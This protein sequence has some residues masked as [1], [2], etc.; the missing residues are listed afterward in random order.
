[1]ILTLFD[2]EQMYTLVLPGQVTGRYILSTVTEDGKPFDLMAVEAEEGHWYLKSNKHAFIAG[3]QGEILIKEKIEPFRT[4]VI[5]RSNGSRAL[6]YVEP[7]T[8]DRNT[9]TKHLV[10]AD[11]IRIGRARDSQ[12]CIANKL[13]S[14]AHCVIEY[15]ANGQ[16]TIIDTNSSN[17]TFVNGKKITRK[18]LEIGDVIYIMGVKIIYNGRLLSLNNP[19]QSVLLDRNAFTPFQPAKPLVEKEEELEDFHKEKEDKDLFFRSPRFKRDIKRREI[20]IDPVPSKTKKDETPLMLLLGPSLTMGLASVMMAVF[21]I[22]NVTSRGGTWTQ[23][24]PMIIM[25]V[26]IL[27]GTVMWPILTKR[28]EKKK[29]AKQEQI[30]HEKYR[31]YLADMRKVIEEE[32]LHQEE[33]LHENHPGLHDYI[34]RIKNRERNLWERAIG[35]DD[36]LLIRVGI[37]DVPL[38]AD[39]K[40]PEKRFTLEDDDLQDELYRLAE[41]PQILRQ[42]PVTFSLIEEKISGIIGERELVIPFVKGL[43][44][45]LTALHSYD[46]CKL[47][48]IYDKS[49]DQIW[50]FVR[51]LPHV[52]DES[53]TIRFIATEANEMKELSSYFEKEI[54][55]RR[56]LAGH[57]DAEFP[58]HYVIF[59]MNK[60]LAAKGEMIN[61]LL[62]EKR[63][64]GFSLITLYDEL[65]D[66]P[67][68]CSTVVELGKEWSKIYDKDDI[69]GRY[70][71][72]KADFFERKDEEEIAI[73]LANTKLASSSEAYRLPDMITFLEMFGVGKIEHLNALERWRENDPTKSLETPI[74]VSTTG[75]LFYLDLHE[76]YHGPHGLVAGMTGSGKSE[77]IM[78]FIL[79]LAVNYHP[80]EVAFILIDYKGGGMANAFLD[81]PHLAGTITNLDGASVKRS[82]VSIQSELKRRQAI[83]SETSRKINVS[84]IDIYKYQKLY[85]EG[86]V[87]EPLQ[88]LFIISDE[89]AELKTQQPEFMEQL[90]SAARIGR[91]LGVHLILATQKPSGV[92]DDQIWSNSKF[93]ICLKVQE[94]QDSMEVIKRPDAAELAQTGR[95][96]L[97]VG[98]NELFEL[99]QSAWSG[100]PYIPADKAEK[101]EDDSV[102]VI[103][104]LGRVIKRAKL[105]KQPRVKNPPKQIDEIVKYLADLAAGENIKVRQLWL[106]PI[107]ALIYLDEL[108]KKY[109]MPPGVWA[110]GFGAVGGLGTGGLLASGFGAGTEPGPSSSGIGSTRSGIGSGRWKTGTLYPAYTGV[111]RELN[112]V[113]GEFDDPANQRQ[114]VLTMPITKEGNAVIYGVTGSGKTTFMST[115]VFSL[116]DTYTPEEVNLYLLDFGTETLRW[117]REAP[118]VGD[119][120]LSHESEK[121]NNLFMLLNREMAARKKKLAEFGGDMAVYN[122]TARDKMPAIVVVIHNYSV[123]SEMY[124]RHEE[125][126]TV[127]TR[128]GTKY[129]LYFVLTG[130][131]PDAVRYRLLQNFKQLFVLQLNDPTDYAGILGN[132]DGVYPSKHKGRGIFKTDKVYEFQV[133]HITRN[134]DDLYAFITEYCRSLDQ[135]WEGRRAQRVPVLPEKVDIHYLSRELA[136]RKGSIWPVGV[137]KTTL[138]TATFDFGRP[139]HLVAASD[140]ADTAAFMQGLAEIFTTEKGAEVIVFDPDRHFRIPE[141]P[142]YG[143]V[144]GR[145]E[146]EPKIVELFMMLVH[147]HNTTKDAIEAGEEPPEFHHVIML[148]HSCSE[149]LALLSAD[150]KDKLKVFLDKVEG[151][152]VTVIL[153]DSIQKMSGY[154]FDPWF[155][156]RVSVTDFVWVG[157]GLADQ[158]VLKPKI[159]GDMYKEIPEGFGYLVAKGKARLVKLLSASITGEKEEEGLHVQGL[160]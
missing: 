71:A 19:H 52:W 110:S 79:S 93:R 129:G 136:A 87:K 92:V 73:K 34:R 109:A 99:G 113:I 59:S 131:T 88:H 42:V 119:V 4:Y 160:N 102:V 127:L 7:P 68:E 114:D 124:D 147:R 103:D 130:S 82:L 135:N 63:Q 53:R 15:D 122:K 58:S 17:G 143:Y 94:K 78:T 101:F 144:S 43:I 77:F 89:F 80:D 14:S 84:N 126:L 49:E 48:F 90:V 156:N 146:L 138:E 100:A 112:P 44:F 95:F 26:S 10:T 97:Q 96:Y 69:T 16:G 83:F 9:Y 65:Q 33:I 45:Q 120:I 25:S 29:Y 121:I 107:P 158:F 133:A 75:D 8:E 91:S 108:Q 151:L 132:V 23:A 111:P 141:Q 35:Q 64:L 22:Y 66:L 159:S 153:S 155:K 149:L 38:Q 60:S 118:H 12:I 134:A 11:R 150:G 1:M 140:V 74:G 50:R 139:I 85:R 86:V 24:A 21:M 41:E 125:E 6:L 123:F 72:F 56:E 54:Q 62:K 106:D 157:N 39:I 145:N 55:R 30:R 81:L 105:D 3:E 36:F 37:G 70:T 61:L 18:K 154:T 117:F 2:R 47:V 98:Y 5:E 40:F 67:K 116:I 142:P 51:W 28:H 115:L 128:E 148:L 57:S 104:N 76:K 32:R 137:D 46:E 27:L 20:K 152:N 31:Q 13:V